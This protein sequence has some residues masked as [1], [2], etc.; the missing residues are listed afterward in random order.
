MFYDMWGLSTGNT[1]VAVMTGYIKCG[2]R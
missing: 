2:S 1:R